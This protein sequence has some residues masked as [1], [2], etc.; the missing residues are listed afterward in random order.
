MATNMRLIP[1]LLPDNAT[2][3]AVTLPSDNASVR[4]VIELILAG[5]EH[6]APLSHVFASYYQTPE[7]KAEAVPGDNVV[8]ASPSSPWYTDSHGISWALQTLQISASNREWTDAELEEMGSGL[9]P[10][11]I[12]LL[13]HLREASH[14]GAYSTDSPSPGSDSFPSA[15]LLA[16]RLKLVCGAPEL[17][18]RLRFAHV[19]EIRDGWDTRLWFLPANA[20]GFSVADLIEAVIEELGIRRVVLQG[21]KSARVEYALA[22]PSPGGPA[23]PLP[24]PPALPAATS[25]SDI[26]GAL[27]TQEHTSQELRYPTLLFTVSATWLNRLG[28]VAA[29]FARHARRAPLGP[30]AATVQKPQTSGVHMTVSSDGPMPPLSRNRS[31]DRAALADDVFGNPT[32]LTASEEQESTHAQQQVGISGETNEDAGEGTVKCQQS[33]S[34]RQEDFTSS[35]DTVIASPSSPTASRDADLKRPKRSQQKVGTPTT[36]RLSRMFEGWGMLSSPAPEP[37]ADLPRSRARPPDAAGRAEKILSVSG[38]IEIGE[39]SAQLQGAPSDQPQAGTS[40][41]LSERFEELMHD[42]GIKGP[43]R[44]AML[45]LPDDRKRFL[46]SQN[47]ATKAKSMTVSKAREG[48]TR[49]MESGPGSPAGF[50]DSMSRASTA[51]TGGWANRFSMA[52]ITSWGNESSGDA[53][54]PKD[55]PVRSPTFDIAQQMPAHTTLD[56]DASNIQSMHTG[57]S[58]TTSLWSSWWGTSSAATDAA[59]QAAG[60]SA[61]ATSTPEWFASQILSSRMTR[62]ELVKTLISLRVTLSSAK[63]NW[64]TQFTSHTAANGLAALEALLSRETAPLLHRGV[65]DRQEASDTVLSECVKCL[66]AIM[67]TEAGF[68]LVCSRPALIV[69]L[70]YS[71]RAPSLRLRCHVADFLAALCVLSLGDGHRLVCSALSELKVATGDRFRFDFLVESLRI[72]DVIDDDVSSLSDA[73]AHDISTDSVH[74]DESLRWDYRT[75]T[76]VLINALANSPEE[77]EER[78]ALRDELARRGLNEVMVSLRYCEPPDALQTQLQVYAEEKQEDLNELEQRRMLS[79]VESRLGDTGK[80]LLDILDEHPELFPTVADIVADLSHIFGRDIDQQSKADLLYLVHKFVEHST[81]MSDFDDGWRSFMKVYLSSVEHL[82]GKQA[83]IKANRESDTSSVPSSFV[84]ELEDLRGQVEDLSDDKQRLQAELQDHV[85]QKSVLGGLSGSGQDKESFAGVIQRL[86]QKEKQVLS[87]QAEL[88]SVRQRGPG[89][90]DAGS[91]ITTGSTGEDDRAKRERQERTRQWTNLMDEIARHKSAMTEM[92]GTVE[93]RDREI[94]YLKRALEAVYARFQS[95]SMPERTV[96]PSGQGTTDSSTDGTAPT[97][98]NVDFDEMAQ[99]SIDVLGQKDALLAERSHSLESKSAEID[100]LRSEIGKLQT[101]MLKQ[102]TLRDTEVTALRAEISGKQKE[103]AVTQSTLTS[104]K[105]EMTRLQDVLLQLQT[106]RSDGAAAVVHRRA[107]QPP[108][109]AAV[110]TSLPMTKPVEP[111]HEKDT[112]MAGRTTSP[113]SLPVVGRELAAAAAPPPPPPPPPATCLS[114]S[115]APDASAAPPPPPPPPFPLGIGASSLQSSQRILTSAPP[116]A[117]PAPVPPPPPPSMPVPDALALNMPPP[118]PPPGPPPPPSAPASA[119][120]RGGFSS[121]SSAAPLPL[122][123]PIRKRK[124]LF[125]NKLS[126]A[127]MA[128]PTVWGD[129]LSPA[130]ATAAV[131]IPVE[132]LD[133][134]FALSQNNRSP[135]KGTSTATKTASAKITTLLE[136]NR[137][138]NIAI[139]LSRI[140]MTLPQIR[141]ALVEV[142]SSRL[143]LDHL[144]A[145]KQCVP[146]PEEAEAV[147]A[148]SGNISTLSKA[149]QLIRELQGIPRL[150]Q[151]ISAMLFMRKFELDLEELKP[152]LKTL[153]EATTELKR[154][155]KLKRILSTVLTIGNALNAST[156]RGSARGFH[157]A[158]LLKLK[159]T[160]PANASS[161]TPTLL[162]FLVRV[163]NKADSSL[164]GFLDECHHVETAARLSTQ[165][166]AQ[167]V[168]SAILG[169]RSVGEELDVLTKARIFENSGSDQFV[170]A[171]TAFRDTA[172]PQVK[173][174]QTA[175]DSIF[176]GLT[177]LVKYFGEDPSQ[178][179]PEEFFT[180][181]SNFGQALMRAEV[182]C[183]QI[184]RKKEEDERRKQRMAQRGFAPDHNAR[185]LRIPPPP[186]PEVR[187]PLAALAEAVGL[188]TRP[189]P[190]G[191]PRLTPGDMAAAQRFTLD[192][193]AS[194]DDATPKPSMVCGQSAITS[195][196]NLTTPGAAPSRFRSWG[197]SA[198]ATL[199]PVGED[200]SLEETEANTSG[201]SAATS[202]MPESSRRSFRRRRGQFD[203]A[204]QELRAGGGGFRTGGGGLG[205]QAGNGADPDASTAAAPGGRSGRPASAFLHAGSNALPDPLP[206][207]VDYGSIS[208][209]KSLRRRDDTARQHR[210]LSRVFFTGD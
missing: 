121:S 163:L 110:E 159:D 186:A 20:V 146:T 203:A 84:E 183:L 6:A 166:I 78:L 194:P 43:S 139:V 112:T 138:Q 94:K 46:I 1:V 160:R 2:T 149:D 147:S 117:P 174:L 30:S 164:V 185:K 37:S 77:L 177:V 82:V 135:M 136:L 91:G 85:A 181:I 40:E 148:F 197:A 76:M 162:H 126:H 22:V 60:A 188:D 35:N 29:G 168:Q 51:F 63:L 101:Q 167:G 75:S 209:R 128:T 45:N 12:P 165:S 124:P 16:T 205:Q 137:S 113:Q 87:L 31:R 73:V 119:P 161:D 81:D 21:S 38:P 114:D 25:L 198:A 103:L 24:P 187:G 195:P 153:K 67:N 48:D 116:S 208:G 104:L 192:P 88:D 107:P 54:S 179:K 206:S 41:K 210:P 17:A 15:H 9:I 115:G 111:S 98:P 202:G 79:N 57:S 3:L 32:V 86:I 100:T 36:T 120:K 74:S 11:D 58:G 175:H 89:S 8:V 39:P 70:A 191:K 180:L 173:A 182:D 44:T 200:T 65:E 69:Y 72:D 184:D 134:L 19:P 26:I 155:D 68:D 201:A 59:S 176:K 189:P 140:K 83:L 18:L 145:L 142:K 133:G 172:S 154:C 152:D 125:W 14:S 123:L 92:Q 170:A 10:G 144:K 56:D 64:I 171:M 131:E 80:L 204:I 34:S 33:P 7:L 93:D 193:Q 169:F 157:M 55:E 132:E 61:T 108:S 50:M 28:T 118:P 52:S 47:D 207:S 151:R 27:Q 95:S 122:N 62:R 4:D 49:R 190:G 105:A 199:A 127:E 102:S 66:R 90:G 158:D 96:P 71:L 109:V 53:D 106:Q 23:A 196:S 5:H 141:A 42:L 99:R 178:T 13:A 150:Q 143:T 129:I 97:P 130:G 156:F